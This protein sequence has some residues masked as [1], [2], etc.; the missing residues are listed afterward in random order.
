MNSAVPRT[1]SSMPSVTRNEGIFSRVTNRP[2]I[3][4]IRAATTRATTK[5]TASEVRPPLNNVHISTGAKPNS[6]PTE[7]SNS[8]AVI[9]SVIAS[10][11]NPSSTVNVSV[12]LTFRTDKKSGL[13]AVKTTS[14]T[15]SRTNGPNSG[16]RISLLASE[17]FCNARHP[18]KARRGW[19]A[20]LTSRRR[21]APPRSDPARVGRSEAAR[22]GKLLARHDLVVDPGGALVVE[23]A[24]GDVEPRRNAAGRH[25]SHRQREIAGRLRVL[26]FRRID[27]AARHFGRRVARVAPADHRNF[28]RLDADLIEHPL[29]GAGH[30]V[31]EADDRLH[32]LAV[33]GEIVAHARDDVGLIERR[34]RDLPGDVER[35]ENRG[36]ALFLL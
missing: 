3:K 12:L 7:R 22:R 29:D 15:T 24:D 33:G 18:E 8:F 5:A 16:A 17:V 11:I 4:P 19:A 2:L 34:V 6:E 13:I 35:L 14:S 27:V 1:T 9:S 25:G 26:P 21:A 31:A 36:D 23:R 32:L 20:P 10:A 28:A 30:H